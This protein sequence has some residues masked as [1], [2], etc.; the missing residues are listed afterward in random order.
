MPIFHYYL[1]LWGHVLGP[2][3][4]LQSA[5]QADSSKYH[6]A[7]ACRILSKSDHTRQSY[8]VITFSGWRPKHRNFTR[9]SWFRSSGKVEIYMHTQIS[10]AYLNPRLR[11]Y[12]FRFLKTNVRY[13]GILLPVSTF[14]FALPSA[15]HCASAYQISSKSDHPRQS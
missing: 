2:F 12:Y 9:L 7:C 15:C 10:V 13:V 4:H 11:Y 3:G 14:T 6:S 8:D 1:L 5:H